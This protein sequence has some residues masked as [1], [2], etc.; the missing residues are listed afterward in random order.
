MS[1]F[2]AKIVVICVLLVVVALLIIKRKRLLRLID[3]ALSKS[4]LYQLILLFSATGIV[5]G[6]LLLIMW[7][8]HGINGIELTGYDRI[9]AFINP[10]TYYADAT[11]DF[12]KIWA[13]VIG[14]FGIVFL[15][16]L[17][18]SVFSNILERRVDKV[19]NGQVC[20]SF[21]N[22]ILII[23]YN[24]MSLGL[25]KQLSEKYPN[26][27]I[28]IQ[29]IQE[30]PKIR[31][32]LFS[33][34]TAAKEKK[35]TFVSGNRNST[36]DL[37]KLH[38]NKCKEV[39]L[40]G[41]NNEYDHDSLNIDCLKKIRFILE[42][43]MAAH[44]KR[45]NVLFEYQY[46]YA[47]FQQQ[48]L[49]K[50]VEPWID[51]VP[52]NFHEIWAQK[53]LVDGR[54]VSPDHKS[55]IKYQWLDRDDVTIDSPKTVHLVVAGMSRMGVAL[56]VQAS[57]LCHFPNYIKDKSKKT[58][59]TFIDEK[60]DVE[61][62]TL[63][64]CYRHFL[65][66]VTHTFED[67]E[68][69]SKNESVCSDDYFTD[70]EW[71]FIKGRIEHPEIQAKIADW[72]RDENTILTIAIC[73]SFPP[74]AISA[75]LYLP[76]VVYDNNI[77]VL[78]RQQTSSSILSMLGESTRYKHVKPFGMLDNA[79]DLNSADD[80]LPMMVKYVYD[81]TTAEATIDAFPSAKMK[82][83]W[84]K[85]DKDSNIS[86]LKWSNRYCANSIYVKQRLVNFNVGEA[87]NEEQVSILAMLEHNRWVAEKLLLGFRAPT[88]AESKEI[89][90]DKEK[91][92]LYRQK[93]IHDD[94]RAYHALTEDY[95]GNNTRMYDINIVKSLP[96]ILQEYEKTLTISNF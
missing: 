19:K 81:H 8:I 83:N 20:Y 59:I 3:F 16:G 44:G 82:E 57:H 64:G 9:L 45:C 49:T 35:I 72:S 12:D 42:N 50:T 43:K 93:L 96:Y 60:A 67:V 85:W 75:G 74:L 15:S 40:L 80:L 25:T 48:Y 5:F 73:F 68:N 92:K 87:L 66:E 86:A 29:T 53:V 78:V 95:A 37:E 76:D 84:G 54:Y 31:H 23:G 24:R 28:I 14:V 26:S 13:I 10:G 90:A 32:D 51:F 36:E 17:L 11:G 18:I 1:I 7:L 30:V 21:Q 41:E 46:T 62:N 91:K 22:H 52:F 47:I 77:P 56:A 4:V 71:H 88:D 34:L 61:I 39:F 70:I 63:K 38:I 27:E 89:A 58:R 33:H 94:I 55:E 2:S 6:L 79:Y 65:E 69:P